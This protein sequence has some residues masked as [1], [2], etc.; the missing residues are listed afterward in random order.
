MNGID[1]IAGYTLTVGT[2]DFVITDSIAQYDPI[3]DKETTGAA[4]SYKN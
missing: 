3:V 2:A 1:N 4:L